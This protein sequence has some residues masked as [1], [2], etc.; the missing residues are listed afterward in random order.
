MEPKSNIGEPHRGA[1]SPP[2]TP[3][4]EPC[5]SDSYPETRVRT[6]TCPRAA[7]ME[8]GSARAPPR[9]DTQHQ[10]PHEALLA[11]LTLLRAFN[12]RDAENR[13]GGT[14]AGPPRT[15]LF[16]ARRCSHQARHEQRYRGVNLKDRPG[17]KRPGKPRQKLWVL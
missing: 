15:S 17:P 12:G 2:S 5:G 3:A 1:Q 10:R 13:K 8:R 7:R 11:A 14:Q 9:R 16:T 6:P 4:A